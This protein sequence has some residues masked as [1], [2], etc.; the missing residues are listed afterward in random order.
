M[1]IWN[2]IG[3]IIMVILFLSLIGFLIYMKVTNPPPKKYNGY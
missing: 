2:T 1:T 3:I